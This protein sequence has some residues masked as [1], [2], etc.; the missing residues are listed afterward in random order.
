VIPVPGSVATAGDAASRAEAAAFGGAVGALLFAIVCAGVVHTVVGW[1]SRQRCAVAGTKLSDLRLVCRDLGY[2]VGGRE[3]LREITAQFPSGAATAVMGPSGAGK[4]TLL[5]ILAGKAKTG[6]VTGSVSFGGAEYSHTLRRSVAYVADYPT[7]MP[8]LT[9]REALAASARLQIPAVTSD[10]E[11]SRLVETAVSQFRIDAVADSA[12]S[13]L[14]AGEL[15]R[16]HI[17]AAT[18]G[19]PLLLLLDEP[20]SGLDAF[21][22]RCVVQCLKDYAADSDEGVTR[23]VVAMTIHQPSESVFR[24]FDHVLLLSGG[25][26][27][28]HGTPLTIAGDLIIGHEHEI[29][30]QTPAEAALEVAANWPPGKD[31]VAATTPAV[32]DALPEDDAADA[33]IALS[34]ERGR[35]GLIAVEQ[36]GLL[37]SR[38]WLHHTR[39]PGILALQFVISSLVAF[40][41]TAMYGGLAKD[42]PGV[43]GRAGL[44]A[45]NCLWVALVNL[46]VIE[47]IASERSTVEAERHAGLYRSGAYVVSK[48]VDD[49][50][51]LR[52]LPSIVAACITYFAVGMRQDASGFFGYVGLQIVFSV[53][54]T[55]LAT[56]L[57][58]S[59]RSFGV[60]SL[61]YGF[62]VVFYFAFGG[63]VSTRESL[64]E[65]LAWLLYTSP[66]FLI[67]EPLMINELDGLLCTFTPRDETGAPSTR[68]ISLSCDQYL[69]NLGLHP[70]HLGTDVGCLIAWCLVFAGAAVLT[71]MRGVPPAR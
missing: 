40:G 26:A 6:T 32:V 8:T 20:T 59:T 21:S 3:I 63:F 24:L 17:A 31:A 16:A 64:P 19:Q 65:G 7:L 27:V 68:T 38:A 69:L 12:V 25:R 60:A 56:A 43:V 66:F 14:S 62:V 47:V 9:V 35:L 44:I 28:Y 50:L 67:L 54:M 11:I 37:I 22:A 5:D 57:A 34:A 49:V 48:L 30:A 13:A 70:K 42:L 71:V 10:A 2:S 41:I 51:L 1:R 46:S 23:P 29:V 45:F 58:A 4:T 33:I 36:C 39:K 18:V 61:A 55:F 52:V 15:K 53:A